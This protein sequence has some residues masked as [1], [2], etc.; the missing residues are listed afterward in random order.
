M[1]YYLWS[2]GIYLGSGSGSRQENFA[3]LWIK[4]L[5]SYFSQEILMCRKFLRI[6]RILR[7]SRNFLHVKI[8]CFTVLRERSLFTAGGGVVQIWKSCEDERATFLPLL[9]SSALKFCSPL[10]HSQYT[11]LKENC[12]QTVSGQTLF[13]SLNEVVIS[14]HFKVGVLDKKTNAF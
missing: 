8:S 10:P 4:E 6:Y 5:P 7:K 2:L 12:L 1:K 3:K 9:G 13:S 14:H 11:S